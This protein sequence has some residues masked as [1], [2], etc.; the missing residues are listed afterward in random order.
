MRSNT[1]L[2]C[3]ENRN[4][5]QKLSEFNGTFTC[6][7]ISKDTEKTRQKFKHRHRSKMAI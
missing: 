7:R 3:V 5:T 2:Y 6:Y 1:D 4:Y